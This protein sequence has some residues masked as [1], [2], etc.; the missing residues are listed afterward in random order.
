[1]EQRRRAVAGLEEDLRRLGVRTGDLLMVHASM[2]ATGPVEGGADG[3]I[4]AL[5]SAVGPAGTLLVNVG[6]EDLWAWVNEHPEPER[7]ALLQGAEPFDPMLTPADPDNGVLAEVFR[8]RPGTVL[9]NHPEG[10]F[11]ACGRLAVRLVSDVPWD[12]YYGPDSPLDRF[13]QENGRVL[14]LGA[15]RDTVTLLH[16][17]E[18]LA[19]LPAKREV[20]RHRLVVG[21]DG[22]ELR[23]VECL[24][25]SEGIVDYPAGDY[26]E[27]ILDDYLC[28]V[29]VPIGLVGGATAE[30]IDGGDMVHFAT[31]WMNK[32]LTAVVQ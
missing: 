29:P 26:F 2:R 14:R 17:A 13:V 18:Y 11:G 31:T 28:S 23:V 16:Y 20:R 27:L 1:M 5:Q 9:S 6:A 22:P 30:L 24:D 15:D 32:H 4:D 8:V 12:H 19:D 21:D 7:A 10:R 25:D 3:L